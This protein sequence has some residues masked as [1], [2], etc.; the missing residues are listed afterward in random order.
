MVV[1]PVLGVDHAGVGHRLEQQLGQV[2]LRRARAD[3]RS[4]AGRAAACPRPGATSGRPRSRP[5]SG[6][7]TRATGSS[8]VRRD[9]SAYPW[10][11]DSGVRSSWEASATNWRTCCSLRCRIVERARTCGRAACSGRSPPGRPRCAGSVR[12]VVDALA[13]VRRR[14]CASGC[15]VTSWAVAATSRSGR[16]WRRT[17]VRPTYGRQ[18]H[19]Q[20]REQDRPQ[21]RRL[22][23][24]SV[25]RCVG[26]P[27]TTRLP[28]CVGLG[29]D[30]V[31][32]DRVRLTVWAWP[33]AG[34]CGE[35]CLRRRWRARRAAGSV[36][37]DAGG[38]GVVPVLASTTASRR[39][40]APGR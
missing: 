10:I 20:Q 33:S 9:S 12:L 14:R 21:I 23:R 3:G 39:C 24:C 19:E 29:R 8:G 17:R 18:R 4:R 34:T 28:L 35:L 5:W 26:R 32:A 27:T 31:V 40:P 7:R 15:S 37:S 11:V 30:A 6:R 13:E 25:A 1:R 16:S 38:P 36:L 2:D 22:S